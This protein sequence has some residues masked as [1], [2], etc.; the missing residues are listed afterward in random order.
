M[1]RTVKA[2]RSD[3][4]GTPDVAEVLVVVIGLGILLLLAVVFAMTG[5]GAHW[6]G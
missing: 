4:P 2:R 1:I 5:T 6:S 3:A